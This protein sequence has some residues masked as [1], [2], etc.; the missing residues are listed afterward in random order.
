MPY[1]YLCLRGLGGGWHGRAPRREVVLAVEWVPAGSGG[2]GG[3][4][5]VEVLHGQFIDAHREVPTVQTVRR[6]VLG[7]DVPVISSDSSHSPEVRILMP[8][9]QF[10]L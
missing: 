5:V 4:A 10:I 3:G 1:H 6:T 7:V 8:K 9:I 2:G